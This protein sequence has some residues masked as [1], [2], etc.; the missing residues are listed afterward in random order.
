MRQIESVSQV[1]RIHPPVG[2][3]LFSPPQALLWLTAPSDISCQRIYLNLVSCSLWHHDSNLVQ[4]LAIVLEG[5]DILG[6]IGWA[7]RMLTLFH[8]P[9]P[10]CLWLEGDS[11]LAVKLQSQRLEGGTSLSMHDWEIEV[12]ISMDTELFLRQF[13]CLHLRWL[14]FLLTIFF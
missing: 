12:T 2:P 8:L 7:G 4:R 10:G 3:S 9:Q 13:F 11:H 6:K 1:A 14:S 5:S